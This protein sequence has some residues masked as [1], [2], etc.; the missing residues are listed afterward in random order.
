MPRAKTVPE[1]EPERIT[2]RIGE[3]SFRAGLVRPAAEEIWVRGGPEVVEGA[4]GRID[5]P[6]V[7]NLG[8]TVA[9]IRPRGFALSIKPDAQQRRLI[10]AKLHTREGR[11][12][13]LRIDLS[14]IVA[15]VLTRLTR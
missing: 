2:M 11:P 8:A 15:G 13:T 3:A 4:A 14:G 7:G 9:R 5:V 6:G 10:V 1:I 12:G